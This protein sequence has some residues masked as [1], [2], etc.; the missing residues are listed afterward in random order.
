MFLYELA[1][2]GWLASADHSDCAEADTTRNSLAA[3]CDELRQ[4]SRAEW[5]LAA[6]T[7]DEPEYPA[8]GCHEQ[9]RADVGHLTAIE[10]A[11]DC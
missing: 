4:C 1:L 5:A 9:V 10:I 2:H 7:D 8:E 3:V 6:G 11:S